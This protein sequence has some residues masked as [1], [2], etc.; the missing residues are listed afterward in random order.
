MKIEAAAVQMEPVF[1]DIE[2]NL[3]RLETLIRVVGDA[4]LV[5]APELVTTGYD[6]ERFKSTAL[7]LAEPADGATV[8]WV[9]RLAR[10][11]DATLVVGFL[12]RGDRDTVHDSLV[13]ASPDRAIVYRKTHLYPPEMEVFA[14]G[15]ELAAHKLSS[16]VSLGAMICFEHAFPE[17]AT[18]LAVDGAEVLVIPSA[19]PRGYEHLLSLR[20]RARAQDNQVFVVASNLTGGDFVGGSLIV[21]PKGEV[22][23]SLDRGEGS[24]AATLDLA[25]IEGERSREPAL[26]LR[27]PE[28]YR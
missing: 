17:V 21:D 9:R 22:M 5:V 26:R 12:E 27:R 4:D 1:G 6:L 10:D 28:L 20:T 11:L 25:M 7:D 23:A 16:G 19:V 24:I 2:H 3:G 8:Q 15:E 13:I 18:T 14:A